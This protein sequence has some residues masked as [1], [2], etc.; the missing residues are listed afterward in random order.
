MDLDISHYVVTLCSNGLEGVQDIK[1]NAHRVK[2][3]RIRSYCKDFQLVL[4][5]CLC[6]FSTDCK[7]FPSCNRPPRQF[8]FVFVDRNCIVFS[9]VTCN[10]FVKFVLCLIFLSAGQR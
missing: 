4:R 9:R 8:I 7:H 3:L 6:S 2:K 10:L 1:A 5:D